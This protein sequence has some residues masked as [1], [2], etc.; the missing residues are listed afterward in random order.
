MNKTKTQRILPCSTIKEK[1]RGGR[2]VQSHPPM[3]SPPRCPPAASPPRHLDTHDMSRAIYKGWAQVPL[4]TMQREAII[5]KAII[6]AQ[7]LTCC[8]SC[9]AA[10]TLR[11]PACHTSAPPRPARRHRRAQPQPTPHSP[12]TPAQILGF[13]PSTFLPWR[14]LTMRSHILVPKFYDESCNQIK[15]YIDSFF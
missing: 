13:L 10:A 2:S 15:K 7:E 8:R 12:I 6:P 11:R 14:E 5:S 4:I 9:S 1:R 3:P